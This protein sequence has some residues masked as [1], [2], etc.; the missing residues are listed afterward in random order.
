MLLIDVAVLGFLTNLP[1]KG[2]HNV[3]LIDHQIAK[4]LQVEEEVISLD[5]EQEEHVREPKFVDLEKDFNVFDRP[6]FVESSSTNSR[7]QPTAQV[8]SN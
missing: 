6:E 3:N 4:I 8:S 5:E 2:T 7:R 1:P